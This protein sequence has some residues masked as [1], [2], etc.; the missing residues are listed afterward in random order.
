MSKATQERNDL[1]Y[2][3]IKK[4]DIFGTYSNEGYFW[5]LLYG[6]ISNGPFVDSV[7]AKTHKNLN[8]IKLE[9]FAKDSWDNAYRY[10]VTK[11]SSLNSTL[12]LGIFLELF[13][14]DRKYLPLFRLRRLFIVELLVQK[15]S[16]STASIINLILVLLT[17]HKLLQDNFML[18][19]SI[20]MKLV[21]D[22]SEEEDENDKINFYLAPTSNT[23]RSSH[24]F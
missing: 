12:F 15:N 21:I 24:K 16:S 5:E 18:I 17:Y 23:P 7:Q 9:K 10:Y 11:Q 19:K 13:I 4:P 8:R 6:E 14:V 22:D 3:P 20:D 2:G 1:D